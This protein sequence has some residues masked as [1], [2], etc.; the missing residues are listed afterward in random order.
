[1]AEN[2]EIKLNEQAFQQAMLKLMEYKDTL[3][4]SMDG[5]NIVNGNMQKDWRGDGG[6][7]FALSSK[8]LEATFV[9]RINDLMQEINDLKDGK[10]SV[11]GLDDFLADEIEK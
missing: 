8:V 5:I 2:K 7:G 10:E 11:F 4:K 1:M 3:I 6:T 9:N